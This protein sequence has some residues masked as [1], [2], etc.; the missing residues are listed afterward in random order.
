MWKQRRRS[1]ILSAINS[2][3]LM[4]FFVLL[5]P[6]L[7]LLTTATVSSTVVCYIFAARCI[8]VYTYYTLYIHK[9]QHIYTYESIYITYKYSC[10]RS[11][12]IITNFPSNSF[13]NRFSIKLECILEM[14]TFYY[15]HYFNSWEEKN[16]C[17]CALYHYVD[18]EKRKETEGKQQK[19]QRQQKHFT[20]YLLLCLYIT[21]AL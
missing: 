12:A 18:I 14:Q 8:G 21:R 3:W 5:L 7:P 10:I 11:L 9:Q 1:R 20:L 16:A 6:L 13:V 17:A 2:G 4:M 15:N 19:Q